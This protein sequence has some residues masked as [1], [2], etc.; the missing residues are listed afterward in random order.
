MDGSSAQRQ[1]GTTH[2]IG[3]DSH[4][5]WIVNTVGTGRQWDTR[6]GRFPTIRKH[7]CNFL[8]ILDASEDNESLV[9]ASYRIDVCAHLPRGVVAVVARPSSASNLVIDASAVDSTP[10]REHSRAEP[11]HFLVTR[12]ARQHLSAHG[13]KLCEGEEQWSC[14]QIVFRDIKLAQ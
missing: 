4:S 5:Q 11:L 1:N 7:D 9:Y 13:M 12:K 8:S 3:S 10:Q 14:H 6:L 2:L